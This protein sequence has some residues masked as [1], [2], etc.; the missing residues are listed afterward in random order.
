MDEHPDENCDD[1]IREFKKRFGIPD[2]IECDD[3]MRREIY[4]MTTDLI[5]EGV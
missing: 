5:N 1:A 4:R 3:A 2:E